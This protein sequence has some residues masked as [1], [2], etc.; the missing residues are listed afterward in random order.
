ME[1]VWTDDSSGEITM[2][3]SPL[4]SNSLPSDLGL[5]TPQDWDLASIESTLSPAVFDPD[6]GGIGFGNWLEID[7]SASANNEFWQWNSTST[8]PNSS[9]EQSSSCYSFL[10]CSDSSYLENNYW[11]I[12]EQIKWNQQIAAQMSPL[13]KFQ[14]LNWKKIWQ[15]DSIRIN[16]SSLIQIIF[17]YFY[18]IY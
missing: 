11:P 16:F 7:Q 13:Q 12:F 4:L 18:P 15:I 3:N 2:P 6:V 9:S 14:V 1:V 10:C 8:T 17:L 5:L